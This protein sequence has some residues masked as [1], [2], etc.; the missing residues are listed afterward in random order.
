[1]DWFCFDSDFKNIALKYY[2]SWLQRGFFF[3]WREHPLK[4]CTRSKVRGPHSGPDPAAGAPLGPFSGTLMVSPCD[5]SSMVTSGPL[6]LFGGSDLHRQRLERQKEPSGSCLA[7]NGPLLEVTQHKL[8]QEPWKGPGQSPVN[9]HE[10]RPSNPLFESEDLKCH[11]DCPL[12]K[13]QKR[14]Q[15]SFLAD[16]NTREPSRLSANI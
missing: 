8:S 1:M 16:Q 13:W 14:G 4:L 10:I 15:W 6:D 7:L 3:G 11:Q 2:F 5:R 12:C 9:F